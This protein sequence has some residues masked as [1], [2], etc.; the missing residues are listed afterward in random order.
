MTPD[1]QNELRRLAIKANELNLKGRITGDEMQMFVSVVNI[2]TVL[3]LLDRI[4]ELEGQLDKMTNRC[5]E[6]LDESRERMERL[7]NE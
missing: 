6:L 7:K 5:T 3:S 2:K 4:K 1:E